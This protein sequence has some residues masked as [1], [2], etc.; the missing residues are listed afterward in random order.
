M[1]FAQ[2]ENERGPPVHPRSTANC[3]AA[4]N[5][6]CGLVVPLIAPT[7]REARG[8]DT[9]QNNRLPRLAVETGEIKPPAFVPGI[10]SGVHVQVSKG[11]IHFRKTAK[12]TRRA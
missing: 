4:A 11:G 3:R 5:P 10:I 9:R 12:L 1:T 6:K 2:V 8:I 7:G